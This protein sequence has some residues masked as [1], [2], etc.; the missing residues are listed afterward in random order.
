MTTQAE[1]NSVPGV[2]DLAPLFGPYGIQ[3]TD[4]KAIEQLIVNIM[5]DAVTVENS[6]N[7]TRAEGTNYFG[8]RIDEKSAFSGTIKVPVEISGLTVV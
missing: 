7:T 6:L 1:W 4:P 3:P 8:N 5:R 2:K